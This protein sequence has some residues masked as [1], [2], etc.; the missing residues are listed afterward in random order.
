MTRSLSFFARSHLLFLLFLPLLSRAQSHLL[1]TEFAVSPTAGEFIEIYNPGPDTVTLGNYYLSDECFNNN[2]NYINVVKG[3]F[4]AFGS[5]FMVK[6]PNG[7]RLAPG[8]FLTIAFTGAGFA[9]TYQKTADF[10]IKGDDANTPDMTAVSVG[11]TAGLS[12]DGEMI[13]LFYWDGQSDLVQDVDYVVWGDKVE[14][15]NK[16]GVS[17][18]GPDA[19]TTPSTYQPDTPVAQQFV[20]DAENDG[21][22]F[23]HDDGKTAQRRLEVEDVETWSGGNGI[24]GHDETSENLSWKGGIWSIHAAATPGARALGDSLNIADVQFKRAADIAVNLSDDSPWRGRTVTLTGVV[25]HGI[26]EIFVGA[27]WGVFVQDERGGPWSGMFVIQNDTSVSGTQFT[28]VQPGDKIRV[29]ALVNEFPGA[30]NTA[31]ITQ[32]ELL[33]N[34]VTPVEFVDF[35]TPRPAPVLLKP[36]DLGAN[37]AVTDPKLTERW[38]SMLVRF[39]NLTVTANGLPGNIMI[40]GDATGSI[41]LDDYFDAV[42]DVVSANGGVW[43]GFPAG[44]RIN[45]TGYIRAGTTQGTVTIN[46]RTINDVEVASSPPA[47]TNVSRDPVVATSTTGMTVSATIV[48]AQTAVA[49]AEVG[50]RVDRGAYQS[51]PMTAGG[52]NL[53]TAVIPAQAN[54]AFVEF[55]I[56]ATDTEGASSTIP[57]DTAAAKLFYFV[58]DAGLTIYDLQYTPYANGNSG[59]TNLTVTVQ[60]IVTTDTTDFSFYWIQDGT[61]PW[62]GIWVN[63]NTTN[64][65][66]GDLV[67]VTGRVEE[68]FNVTRLVNPSSANPLRVTILSRGNPLPTPVLLRTGDLRTGAATAEQWEGMLVQVRNAVVSNPFPDAPSNFGEF[69]IDDGSGEVRVDDLGDFDGNLDSIYVKGDSIRSLTAIHHYSFNNYK[70]LPR[71]NR[72]V[73]RGPGTG[74]ADHREPPLRYALEQNYPNPFNPE[75]AIRYQLPQPGR[76]SLAIYNLLGQKVKTLVDGIAPAGSHLTKWDG[77]NDRGQVVP[78]G[79]YFYRLRTGSFEKVNKM[80]LLR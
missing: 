52:G 42:F 49:S 29:T 46:P 74:V 44:T 38:E 32:L 35:G 59:Y 43:P 7:S 25:M 21:D 39:E 69:A 79:V 19:D 64:V 28:A 34:P 6:F 56:K 2:N 37:G 45:V 17:I 36:G 26:R 5:D 75:T 54:G 22:A 31:S 60:G 30:A 1:I 4:T 76:V 67:S 78:G 57:A 11:A 33:T 20:V 53:Y 50:Y 68:N 55:F 24:A 41:A 58:R 62:R 63:D 61:T 9:T 27:R 66:A 73:V 14:A 77:T 40:A 13:V 65:K 10:E 48:D 12:N 18:D 3:G 70:L 71:N 16:T 80:L 51:L 23:P 15:I 47:I 8:K 72:D